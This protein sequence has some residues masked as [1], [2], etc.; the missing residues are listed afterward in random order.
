MKKEK[1]RFNYNNMLHRLFIDSELTQEKFA[2]ILDISRNR[3]LQIIYNKQNLK[4]ST[5]LSYVVL[6]D[7][8]LNI[9]INI[10][11]KK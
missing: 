2:D 9:N 6:L 3:L 4:L 10:E 1:Q 8:S 11:I 5:F 7:K